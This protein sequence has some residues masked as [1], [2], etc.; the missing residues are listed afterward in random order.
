MLSKFGRPI[1]NQPLATIARPLHRWGITPNG[2]SIV[3]FLLTVAASAL[4]AIGELRWGGV[5]LLIAASFDMLD[6]ALARHTNQVSKFGAFLDSTLDRYSESIT[7]LGLTIFYASH[8]QNQLHLVLI[9]LALIGSWMVS[10]TR[11]RAEGLQI[12]RKGGLLQRPERI[13]ILIAGLIL[14]WML[15]VL[16]VLAVLTNFTALQRIRAVYAQTLSTNPSQATID[17]E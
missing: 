3:G 6:G 12:E 8:S 9:F 5:L 4:L 13:A 10:Y 17:I 7:L 2:I 1:L 11:A 16:W 14:G 15:P